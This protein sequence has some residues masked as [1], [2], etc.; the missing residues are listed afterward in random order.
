M[1]DADAMY[2]SL[3]AALPAIAWL[4]E[5]C[6]IVGGG[7]RDVLVGAGPKDLDCAAPSAQAAAAAFAKTSEGRLVCLARHPLE[8]WRVVL[9]GLDWDFTDIEGGSIEADLGRRDFT[10]GAL[11][12]SVRTPHVLIDLFGGVDDVA[13]RL[14]RMVSPSNMVADP[15]RMLR[16][17]RLAGRTGFDIEPETLAFISGN[18]GHLG[19]SA[20]ERI[21]TEL[22]AIA[23]LREVERPLELLRK[24][25]L[26]REVL[27]GGL[28]ESDVRRC[29]GIFSCDCVARYAALFFD[30][31]ERVEEH[32]ASSRWSRDRRRDVVALLGFVAR[33]GET[34]EAGLPLL[35]HDYGV[36][37]ARRAA[38]LLAVV[39]RVDLARTLSILVR[40]RGAALE[41]T[42]P[43]LSGNEIRELLGIEDGP[44]VGTAL[45]RLIEAQIR[46]SVRNRAEALAFFRRRDA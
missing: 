10:I 21:T 27:P 8:T 35:V 16:A 3:R 39:G 19:E 20:P 22:D 43:L 45:R 28:S 2:R 14:V 5:E 30:R 15:V 25:N 13:H 6:W 23:T 12:L 11:A 33:A 32:A 26:D 34:G 29:A 44:D 42:R 38:E 40:E 37:T 46:G 17:V 4:P 18:A 9:N 36:R 1:T 31:E 41:D 7:L 24:T